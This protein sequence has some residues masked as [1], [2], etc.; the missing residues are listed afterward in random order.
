MRFLLVAL[1]A[2]V[3]AILADAPTGAD[4]IQQM[5]KEGNDKLQKALDDMRKQLGV[6]E[7][8]SGEE[9]VK[10]MKEKNDKMGEEIKKWRAKVE[11]Q[12][13][14]NPDASAALKNIKD[15]LKEAQDKLKKE[16][17]DIAKNAEK[18]GESIKSTWDSITQEVEKSYKD[19]SK[20]GGKQEDIENVFKNIV[21]A[22][23]KAANELKDGVDKAINKKP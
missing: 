17:P 1:F 6:S 12:I 13:K 15:K 22:G 4:T 9:L 23:V 21:D 8:P 7:N 10:L 18:L 5:I 19:F 2:F 3:P 14:N 11:E 16:N 20:K